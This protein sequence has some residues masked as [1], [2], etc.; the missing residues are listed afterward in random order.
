MRNSHA[1]SRS[2]M[3][4]GASQGT[5]GCARRRRTAPCGSPG[6]APVK[7]IVTLSIAVTSLLAVRAT[8]GGAPS[9]ERLERGNLVMEDIPE[10][11]PNLAARL[12]RY[13]EFRQAGFRDWTPEGALLIGTR[14]GNVDQIHLVEQPLGPQRQ[15]TAFDEPVTAALHSPGGAREGFAFLMDEG[16][17]E[18]AQIFF[19][20]LRA[21][22]A[23]EPRQLTHG[24][25]LNGGIVWANRGDRFAFFSNRRDPT[26]YDVYVMD[27]A[28]PEAPKMIIQSS[29]QAWYPL[30]WSP[31]DTRLLLW[32]YVSVNDSTLHVADIATGNRLQILPSSQRVG[33][34][35]ARFSRDGR[36]VYVV[37][38]RG[39]EFKQLR[40]VDL[41][42]GDARTLS[43][44]VRWDVED[45]DLS[46]DGRYLAYVTNEDGI[47]RLNLLDLHESRELPA[48]R[49]SAGMIT[50]LGFDP[51]SRRL[52]FSF[53]AAR[54]PRDVYVYDLHA[55][56]LT[57]W[58]RSDPADLDMERM[59]EPQLIRYPTFDAIA[60]S[61]RMIS[62]RVR[63]IDGER[64]RM[65]EIP[66]FLY[67]PAG[68]GPFPVVIHIHGGPEQQYRPGFEA[69]IQFA[70][71]ELGYAVVAPNVRGSNGYGKSYLDLDNGYR[72]EDAVK[73]IGA[74]LDWIHQQSSLDQRR[75]AVM[76]GSYGGY[77]VLASLVQF[78]ERLR[79][80][81]N[82]V[83]ISNYLTFLANTSEYRRDL[84]RM[85]YGDE[86][87]PRM[88]DFLASISPLTHAHRIN[89][90]LLVVQ[91]LNDPRVP[92][93]ESEQLV[94][95][96]RAN[97]GRVWY[98][99]AKD[100]GHGFRKKHNRD[101]YWQT[102]ASFL[103]ELARAAP[104][105]RRQPAG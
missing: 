86:R 104:E 99:M 98:L 95:R 75:V 38:D 46:D 29:G 23:G 78:G 76:G 53:E 59:V 21:G 35:T 50:N 89:R 66:A 40:Y 6:E 10:V 34:R 56:E 20:P 24:A 8:T 63:R 37:S 36:G 96:V 105:N 57:R 11:A 31:D 39:S 9:V 54:M 27:P 13:L 41:E 17:D 101:V 48:P 19:Q 51:H 91:G 25:A 100:E 60:G 47:S 68:R 93:S 15:L 12:D 32:N 2:H 58:T 102:V 94:A 22:V 71:N 103:E 69:F 88:R 64:R 77:M 67:Q 16:G 74:L 1:H 83:G 3:I 18:N 61:Q 72:R 85:E 62:V 5:Y 92:A 30:D 81:V 82:T 44:R 70:V 14:S 49:L 73:D 4:K 26:V 43:D 90:P 45:L 84:R 79:G 87:D 28:K 97:G 52:A 7:K 42:T 80:G 65:R 55:A 33:I